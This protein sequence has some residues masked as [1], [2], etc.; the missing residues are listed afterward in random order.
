MRHISN[1]ALP[2]VFLDNAQLLALAKMPIYL[3]ELTYEL[4]VELSRR[5]LPE[6]TN[7]ISE[8]LQR[9]RH[10][11][12]TELDFELR[13]LDRLAHGDTEPRHDPSPEK[14]NFSL[15]TG[16]YKSV[17]Q[18]LLD[19]IPTL[20]EMKQLDLSVA[21]NRASLAIISK[22]LLIFLHKRQRPLIPS[23]IVALKLAEE[24]AS[25]VPS[26]T[27]E[28]I[29]SVPD[30]TSAPTVTPTKKIISLPK[31]WEQT[32]RQIR[33]GKVHPD[34][35]NVINLRSKDWADMSP[36]KMLGYSVN[37]KD[38]LAD[39][40]REEFLID[41]CESAILPM[42]LPV[43]Y[44]EPWGQPNTKLRV[45]RTARHLGFLRKNFERQDPERFARS[46]S[47]WRRDFEH[48]QKRYGRLLNGTEWVNSSR[49]V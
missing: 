48:L 9:Y 46:I 45:L 4:C 33:H 3:P 16:N 5:D 10:S 11:R 36:L 2:L 12:Q 49:G 6:S 15:R 30:K 39:N 23:E 18:Y 8:L 27:A 7:L 47:C 43:A 28:Q 37:A 19:V 31:T 17:L 42:N 35:T 40:E 32:A 20:D 1:P 26:T 14:L 25:F 38:G 13:A 44:A 24:A 22:Q 34:A 29:Q 21:L 41:F